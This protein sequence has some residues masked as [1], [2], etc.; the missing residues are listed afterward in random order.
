MVVVVIEVVVVTAATE[1]VVVVVIVVVLV[2][3]RSAAEVYKEMKLI[4]RSIKIR[5][6]FKTSEYLA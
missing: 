5:D 4:K 3:I 2:H 1:I 6:C